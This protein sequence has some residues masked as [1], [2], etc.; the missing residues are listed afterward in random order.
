MDTFKTNFPELFSHLLSY[1]YPTDLIALSLTSTYYAQYYPTG[2]S[3]WRR[4]ILPINEFINTIDHQT[5]PPYL[6][7]DPHDYIASEIDAGVSIVKYDN[8]LISYTYS[9]DCNGVIFYAIIDKLDT[10]EHVMCISIS[11][12]TRI[13]I[14]YSDPLGPPA[15]IPASIPMR[16]TYHYPTTY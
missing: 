5:Y 6:D 11:D 8:K 15:L 12:A 4:N 3:Q 10:R 2:F 14:S 1:L 16:L 7:D 13:E 9:G